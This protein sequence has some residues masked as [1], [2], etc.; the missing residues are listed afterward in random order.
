MKSNIK[1]LHE[2]SPHTP[3]K[4]PKGKISRST[5]K[6]LHM[7]FTRRCMSV[8]RCS[9]L[10]APSAVPSVQTC[11]IIA[12]SAFHIAVI[13]TSSPRSS[14]AYFFYDYVRAHNLLR[15]CR[16]CDMPP[17]SSGSCMWGFSSLLS[18]FLFVVSTFF[19]N[20]LQG[21]QHEHGQGKCEGKQMDKSETRIM[22]SNARQKEA[23]HCAQT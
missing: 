6:M 1:T 3:P 7:S 18:P 10:P 16:C 19:C 23:L 22:E 12:P 9:G 2:F 21:E 11:M 17:R 15:Q 5:N 20:G 8:C 13:S 4:T 14:R